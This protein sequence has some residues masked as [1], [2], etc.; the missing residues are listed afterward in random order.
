MEHTSDKGASSWLTVVPVEELGFKLHKQAF[1]DAL[2]L[3]YGW[4]L[5]CIP[6]HCACGVPLSVDHAF[7]CPKGGLP[8]IRHNQ[9]R[10]L[11]AKLLSEVCLC[12]SVEPVLQPLSGE[13]F[14]HRSAIIVDNAGLDVCACNFWNKS[15]STAFFDVKVFNALAVSNSSSSAS[16]CFHKHELDKRRKYEQWILKV[17]GGMFTPFHHVHQWRHRAISSSDGQATCH[18]HC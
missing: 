17:E 13:S 14:H 12:V 2:C 5:S 6:S 4:P 11:L 7:S 1:R 3:R 10:D 8:T 15:I 16:S 18:T 9:I